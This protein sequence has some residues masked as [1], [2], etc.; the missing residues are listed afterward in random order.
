TTAGFLVYGMSTNKYVWDYSCLLD[1]K[2]E[3]DPAKRDVWYCTADMV[4]AA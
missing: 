2:G 3:T 4:A 1:M